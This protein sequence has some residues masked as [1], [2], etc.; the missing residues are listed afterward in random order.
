MKNERESGDD[1]EFIVAAERIA[2]RILATDRD[3]NK[4]GDTRRLETESNQFS[5]LFRSLVMPLA[6]NAVTLLS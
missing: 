1:D 3:K 2:I 5:R 6:L 4:Q